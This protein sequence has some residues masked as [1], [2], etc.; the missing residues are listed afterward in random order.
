[1][2]ESFKKPK[3]VYYLQ[4]G[5]KIE[6][7]KTPQQTEPDWSLIRSCKE[8]T[9]EV[10]KN[11]RNLNSPKS[12]QKIS[13]FLKSVQWASVLQ[14]DLRVEFLERHQELL[15][16]P[17]THSVTS[18]FADSVE[19]RNLPKADA[20]CGKISLHTFWSINQSIDQ[21]IDQSIDRSM[22]LWLFTRSFCRNRIISSSF[23]FGRIGSDALALDICEIWIPVFC[24][25]SRKKMRNLNG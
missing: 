5:K 13:F 22:D 25:E 6:H 19:E 15:P 12:R 14:V 4:R 3:A 9:S 1:M 23:F 7:K 24:F 17:A 10:K 18:S 20:N 2:F 21:R 8:K 11:T 16:L